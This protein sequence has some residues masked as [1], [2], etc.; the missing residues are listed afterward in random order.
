[1]FCIERNF[2]FPKFNLKILSI[3]AFLKIFSKSFKKQWHADQDHDGTFQIFPKTSNFLVIIMYKDNGF[4]A[5]FDVVWKALT[6]YFALKILYNFLYVNHIH[7][8]SSYTILFYWTI[9]FIAI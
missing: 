6:E 2:V 8:I 1:M 4:C 7:F 9:Q 5:N 3:K